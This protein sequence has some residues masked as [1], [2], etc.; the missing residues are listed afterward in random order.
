MVL[1]RPLDTSRNEI[2]VIHLHPAGSSSP[3]TSSTIEC[4][5]EHVSLGDYSEA[6]RTFLELNGAA[7]SPV[8]RAL[9]WDLVTTQPTFIKQLGKD[10][11]PNTPLGD[12]LAGFSESPV[13][14]RDIFCN[15]TTYQWGDF[16][17]LSYEGVTRKLCTR[18]GGWDKNGSIGL[19][20]DALCINQADIIERNYQVGQ[21]RQIYTS[22]IKVLTM[23]GP[24]VEDPQ[25]TN[26]LLSKIFRATLKGHA[27][28]GEPRMLLNEGNC[29]AWKGVCEIAGRSY[30]S[31]LWIIQE[32]L[33]ANTGAWLCYGGKYRSV[34]VFFEAVYIIL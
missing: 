25:A 17:A 33:L 22:A 2:R 13:Y 5:L 20:V 30:W 11:P 12:A 29:S 21:M 9:L 31:R 27:S 14:Q 19:W 18:W 1:Y 10:A 8:N 16:Y 34:S 6:Y 7:K 28:P 32:V 26:E 23:T 15:A 4:T 24:D 3:G